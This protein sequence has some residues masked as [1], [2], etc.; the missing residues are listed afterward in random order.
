MP[1]KKSKVNKNSKKVIL[2]KKEKK[3]LSKESLAFKVIEFQKSKD[4]EFQEKIFKEIVDQINPLI[5][6]IVNKF[7]IPGYEQTDLYQEALMAL[8]FKA[9]KDFKTDRKRV[10]AREYGSIRGYVCTLYAGSRREF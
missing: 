6:K 5:S 2:A 7:N 8:R 3:S 10:P 4:I 9:I 1:K